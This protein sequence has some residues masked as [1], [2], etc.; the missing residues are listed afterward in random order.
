MLQTYDSVKEIERKVIEYQGAAEQPNLEQ[1][2]L[3]DIMITEPTPHNQN[4][5]NQQN[6]QRMA[7]KDIISLK[8]QIKQQED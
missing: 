7:L 8:N 6:A 4:Q 3:I 5:Q 2:V 1:R